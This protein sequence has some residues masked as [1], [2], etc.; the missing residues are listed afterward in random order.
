M[1]KQTYVVKHWY[2]ADNYLDAEKNDF[3]RV[4]CKRVSTALRYLAG[5]R[6]Q[7]KELGLEKLYDTLCRDD[8]HYEIVAT[9]N[10]W[11]GT[12]VVAKGMMKDL[13]KKYTKAA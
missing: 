7:A 13:E 2:G 10:G 1:A 12:E 5:W 8:A 3:N 4:S 9:P 11:D 6:R